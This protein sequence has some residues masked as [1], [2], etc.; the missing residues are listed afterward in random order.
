LYNGRWYLYDTIFVASG[1]PYETFVLNNIVSNSEINQYA[2]H[3]FIDVY[4][5]RNNE[6]IRF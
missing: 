4:V 5:K 2:A 1:A 6:F 3:G